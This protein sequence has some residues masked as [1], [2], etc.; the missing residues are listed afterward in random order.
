MRLWP[1]GRWRRRV[2]IVFLLPK[3]NWIM[4]VGYFQFDCGLWN[5]QFDYM[6]SGAVGCRLHDMGIDYNIKLFRSVCSSPMPCHHT[7]PRRR[8]VAPLEIAKELGIN[9]QVT[10]FDFIHTKSMKAHRWR[11]WSGVTCPIEIFSHFHFRWVLLNCSAGWEN[12]LP[13]DE[14]Q[15]WADL[16]TAISRSLARRQPTTTAAVWWLKFEF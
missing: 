5:C 4:S 1:V 3:K 9:I 7:R 14:R 8:S 10:A 13:D 2:E 12:Y 16:M 11:P 15:R 6:E